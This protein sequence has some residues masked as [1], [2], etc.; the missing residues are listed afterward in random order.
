[1]FD[2]KSDPPTTMKMLKCFLKISVPAVLTNMIAFATVV[3]NGVFAGH[4]DRPVYLASMGLASVCCNIMV[5]SVLIGLN[6]AQETLTSQAFGAGNLQLCGI[7]LNRGRF[8]LFA[9]VL[10]IALI[11]MVFGEQILLAIG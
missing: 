6:G 11:P 5:L 4:M 8:I 7:Y 2:P 1:M 9:F 3:T 10:P